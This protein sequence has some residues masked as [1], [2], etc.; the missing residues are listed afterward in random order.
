MQNNV[1]IKDN[2]TI[3]ELKQLEPV[4]AQLIEIGTKLDELDAKYKI[5]CQGIT[6]KNKTD[7]DDEEEDE[8]EVEN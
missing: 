5:V 1:N 3:E 8:D 6:L 2:V 7:A 4:I